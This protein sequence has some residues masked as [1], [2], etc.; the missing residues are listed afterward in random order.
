MLG[1]LANVEDRVMVTKDRDFEISHSLRRSPRRLLLVTTGNIANN[2]LLGLFENNL[3]VIEQ[4]LSSSDYVELSPT[5]VIVQRRL[6]LGPPLCSNSSGVLI[7]CLAEGE[8]ASRYCHK[9]LAGRCADCA[10][11][12]C[13]A[14]QQILDVSDANCS[15]ISIHSASLPQSR[16]SHAAGRRQGFCWRISAWH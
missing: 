15:W 4:E 3:A 10:T 12:E 8:F 5:A 14:R 9:E 2:A 13:K 16:R 6:D 11:L 7:H 1:E